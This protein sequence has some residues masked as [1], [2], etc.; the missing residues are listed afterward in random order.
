MSSDSEV[1]ACDW[2]SAVAYDELLGFCMKLSYAS[3]DVV[4][5]PL[6]CE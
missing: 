4:N 2:E 3:E 1:S 5:I 6:V